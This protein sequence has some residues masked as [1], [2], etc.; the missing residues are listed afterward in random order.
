[1]KNTDLPFVGLHAHSTFS[2]NDGFGYPQEHQEYA[3]GNGMNALA[4]TDHGTCAGLS[5]AILN[6]KKMRDEGKEFKAILGVE[7]Y[8]IPDVVEW[9]E[10]YEEIKQDKKA[11][12]ALKKRESTT[13]AETDGSSR[14][15]STTLPRYA[16]LILFAQSQ[17]GLNNIYSIVSE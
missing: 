3:Y 14:E 8:F 13:V 11:A 6:A 12:R 7:A 15:S 2:L 9:R 1:M 10:I 4:L 5:Y 17:V 16:H